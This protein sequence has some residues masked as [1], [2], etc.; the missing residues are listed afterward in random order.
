ME[1]IINLSSARCNVTPHIQGPRVYA[2]EALL[3]LYPKASHLHDLHAFMHKHAGQ[4][5][6]I[7]QMMCDIAVDTLLDCLDHRLCEEQTEDTTPHFGEVAHPWRLSIVVHST[8]SL[9]HTGQG[10]LDWFEQMLGGI[11]GRL[12]ARFRN[13]HNFAVPAFV[14]HGRVYQPECWHWSH[15]GGR[16]PMLWK[17]AVPLSRVLPNPQHGVAH[18]MVQPMPFTE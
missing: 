16:Q 1:G 17:P 14:H 10:A 9:A 3:E 7:L 8:L 13:Y 5:S 4:H 2:R 15:P 12:W 11:S 18:S 6:E